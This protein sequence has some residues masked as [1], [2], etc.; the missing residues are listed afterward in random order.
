MSYLQKW[1]ANIINAN[2]L[3][4]ECSC[5]FTQSDGETLKF[6][7]CN[8]VFFKDNMESVNDWLTQTDKT[9]GEW[10]SLSFLTFMM[11]C[12]MFP[13][14]HLYMLIMSQQL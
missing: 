5:K 10:L 13:A 4:A 1:S 8:Q 9:H 3:D 12:C 6:I 7:E 14:P 11:L 2:R